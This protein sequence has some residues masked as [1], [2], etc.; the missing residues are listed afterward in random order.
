M[1]RTTVAKVPKSPSVPLCQRGMKGGFLSFFARVAFLRLLR[2]GLS[3]INFAEVVLL[4]ICK[5]R[6]QG[7][8]YA[9]AARIMV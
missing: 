8:V 2:T 4:N 7:R 1:T 9:M 3:A 6:I 5:V